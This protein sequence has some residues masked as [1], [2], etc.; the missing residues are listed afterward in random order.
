MYIY[1]ILLY[2]YI[3]VLT[4]PYVVRFV[5]SEIESCAKVPGW[6]R[7]SATTTLEKDFFKVN[8]LLTI[9]IHNIHVLQSIIVNYHLF[10]YNC[11]T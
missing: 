3:I 7:N 10:L 9:T 4:I 11:H 1:N 2:I 8:R 6:F 5:A